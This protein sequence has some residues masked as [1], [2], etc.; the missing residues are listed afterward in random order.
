M[1]YPL[2]PIQL[3]QGPVRLNP[4]GCQ[5]PCR[6]GLATVNTGHRKQQMRFFASLSLFLIRVLHVDLNLEGGSVV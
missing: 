1:A 2:G 3:G 5:T 4:R 6:A